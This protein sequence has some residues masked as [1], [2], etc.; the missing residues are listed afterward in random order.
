VCRRVCV[1]CRARV[2]TSRRLLAGVRVA[3]YAVCR[4]AVPTARQMWQ[5]E[6]FIPPSRPAREGSGRASAAGCSPDVGAQRER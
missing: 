5:A 2:Q 1:V 3:A 6:V 4:S